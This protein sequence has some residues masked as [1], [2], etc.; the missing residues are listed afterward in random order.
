MSYWNVKMDTKINF[1]ISQYKQATRISIL[2]S[3]MDTYRMKNY[4]K[5][6]AD[7]LTNIT[8]GL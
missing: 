6:Y 5:I 1:C 4:V 3:I 8:L 2:T 7:K